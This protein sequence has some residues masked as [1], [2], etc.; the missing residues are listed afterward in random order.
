MNNSFHYE[1]RRLVTIN[2]AGV[3]TKRS[4]TIIQHTQNENNI[5]PLQ[6][7]QTSQ[8]SKSVE[9]IILIQQIVDKV[10]PYFTRILI[11]FIVLCFLYNSELMSGS[12]KLKE[13]RLELQD[14]YSHNFDTYM[15]LLKSKYPSQTGLFWA[16]IISTYQH[17]ILRSKDPA[18]ILIVSDNST[19]TTAS[20]L[21][22]DILNMIKKS[23]EETEERIFNLNDLVI[24]P[25][26][27][28]N[29]VDLIDGREADKV[30]LHIDTK[31][32]RLFNNGQRIALVKNVDVIPATSMLLF[33]TY[34]DDLMS[35]KF[36]G[37]IILMTVQ[38]DEI[39][40]ENY[41][42]QK[43]VTSLVEKHLLETWSKDVGEDQLKPLFTRIANNVVL[44]RSE[45]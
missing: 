44:V 1:S 8:N 27:D 24:S 39:I 34:G 22:Y 29:L 35:A 25:K 5:Y 38:L 36:P 12:N 14:G 4:A 28:P 2:E 6:P 33:Y 37:V 13:K 32:N 26:S 16:N 7:Y 31:L 17:T 15:K 10:R 43:D 20:E 18:I 3:V 41:L 19:K 45:N 30:K 9:W 42:K 23:I 11:A 40:Q 21:T